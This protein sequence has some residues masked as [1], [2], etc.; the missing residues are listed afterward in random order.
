M[1]RTILFFN[2][3][4]I[5]PVYTKGTLAAKELRL[6]AALMEIDEVHVIAPPGPSLQTRDTTRGPLERRYLFIKPFLGLITVE[7]SS[8]F[9][10]VSISS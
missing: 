10:M 1:K 2:E 4:P 5:P 8:I 3:N 7:V 6:R 9:S